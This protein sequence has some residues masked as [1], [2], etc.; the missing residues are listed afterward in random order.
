MRCHVAI[1]AGVDSTPL[2]AA[3]ESGKFAE[4][5]TILFATVGA[6]IVVRL[7]LYRK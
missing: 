2:V 1:H 4:A 7:A 5:K 3:I 6:G